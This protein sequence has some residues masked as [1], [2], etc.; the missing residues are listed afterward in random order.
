MSTAY[1]PEP[2]SL[3]DRVCTWLRRNRDE[4]LTPRDIATKFDVPVQ[5]LHFSLRDAMDHGWILR[6]GTNGSYSAG[7]RLPT[8][9]AL[10]G[11]PGGVPAKPAPAA[12]H[13]TRRASA[14]LDPDAVAIRAGVPIPPRS[15]NPVG[16]SVY[17]TLLERMK[18]G[19][20][21]EL[22][23]KQAASLKARAKESGIRITVR[24]LGED[25]TG[26]WRVA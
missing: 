4:E 20:M 18:P 14:P 21:V 13:R 1:T 3:A 22:T 12:P 8:S 15:S 23:R 17:L 2:G 24:R 6:S 10:A 25:V 7:P 11:A 5:G 19:D 16:R 26:I 9:A